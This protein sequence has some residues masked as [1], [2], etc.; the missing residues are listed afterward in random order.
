MTDKRK[1]GRPAL[2]P[3]KKLAVVPVRLTKNQKAKLQRI[4]VQRFRDWLDRVREPIAA[5]EKDG[6]V[7]A[8]PIW[9]TLAEIGESAPAGT[10]DALPAQKL[11]GQQRRR[12][13]AAAAVAAERK[14]LERDVASL[15]MSQSIN[16]QN[17]P[18]AWHDGVDAALE[19][20]RGA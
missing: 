4:G 8:P 19:V 13:Y 15:H 20:I 3:D 6:S 9:E 10:W 2:P 12:G 11:Q 17:Y 5:L 18:S 1:P 14:R 7:T 16:N